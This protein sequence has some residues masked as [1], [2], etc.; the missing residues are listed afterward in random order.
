MGGRSWYE[1]IASTC[2][3]FEEYLVVE[4]NIVV[5]LDEK[6]FYDLVYSV[7]GVLSKSDYPRILGRYW[8]E[9]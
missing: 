6:A 7:M 8:A 2:L 1:G 9:L 5:L 4:A 3:Y